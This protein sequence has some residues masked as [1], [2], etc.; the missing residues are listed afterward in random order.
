M[1][2]SEACM[3]DRE[4]KGSDELK[5]KSKMHKKRT[6]VQVSYRSGADDGAR[7]ASLSLADTPTVFQTVHRTV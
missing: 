6:P 7:S 1:L 5:R 4:N 2:Q 3:S